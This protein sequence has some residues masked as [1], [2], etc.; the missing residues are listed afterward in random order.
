MAKERA[1]PRDAEE[2]FRRA[3]QRFHATVWQRAVPGYL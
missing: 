1:Q 3:V 2:R